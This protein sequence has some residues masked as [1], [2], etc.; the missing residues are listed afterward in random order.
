MTRY[1]NGDWYMQLAGYVLQTLYVC[2]LDPPLTSVKHFETKP[3]PPHCLH[4][5]MMRHRS[6]M[7]RQCFWSAGGLT[8]SILC[9]VLA[10]AYGATAL[11]C[12]P[13]NRTPSNRLQAQHGA[14]R[15]RHGGAGGAGRGAAAVGAGGLRWHV[16]SVKNTALSLPP[17]RGCTPSTCLLSLNQR[18]FPQPLMGRCEGTFSR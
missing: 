9:F 17:A 11:T 16:P 7:L 4:A 15:P 8:K 12:E 3:S 5:R 18:V 13:R 2:D 1:S 10:A 14:G 6:V